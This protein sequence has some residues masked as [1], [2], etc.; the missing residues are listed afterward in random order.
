MSVAHIFWKKVAMSLCRWKIRCMVITITKD[1]S[2]VGFFFFFSF[3]VD[4]PSVND[5]FMP[6]CNDSDLL[7][8]LRSRNGKS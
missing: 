2:S 7:F 1:S 3:L 4:N 5:F 6:N 8:Y